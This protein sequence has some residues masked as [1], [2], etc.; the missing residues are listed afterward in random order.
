MTLAP[1]ETP[2]SYAH[3]IEL[4]RLVDTRPL[5]PEELYELRDLT[6][7]AASHLVYATPAKK[8]A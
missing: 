8:G 3:K 1:N 7:L 4:Q 6:R 5:C 2:E